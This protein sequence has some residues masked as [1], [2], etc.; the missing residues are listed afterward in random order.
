MELCV[1]FHGFLVF[2]GVCLVFLIERSLNPILFLEYYV[3]TGGAGFIGANIVLALLEKDI[4]CDNL[5]TN[6]DNL[7]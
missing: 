6:I 2:C 7:I 4:K 3:F 5:S 1:S